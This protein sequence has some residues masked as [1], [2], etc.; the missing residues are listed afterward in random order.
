VFSLFPIS[1][2]CLLS[3]FLFRFHLRTFN[4]DF[5]FIFLVQF[6]FFYVRF[7]FHCVWFHCVWFLLQFHYF[8][9]QFLAFDFISLLLISFSEIS[10][11]IRRRR[12]ILSI[13]QKPERYMHNLVVSFLLGSFC[14]NIFS[15]LKIYIFSFVDWFFLSFRVPMKKTLTILIKDLWISFL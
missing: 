7:Q 9:F 3:L 15:S 13:Y 8:L 5:V 1:F 10:L 2:L 12:M 4:F 11:V 14:G 6:Q